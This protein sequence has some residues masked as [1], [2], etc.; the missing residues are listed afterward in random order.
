MK[1]QQQCPD[2]MHAN[3]WEEIRHFLLFLAYGNKNCLF[4]ILPCD[5]KLTV[6]GPPGTRGVQKINA[7]G[8]IGKN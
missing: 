4:Q 6:R 3:K 7:A 2:Q 1:R 8:H 5:K